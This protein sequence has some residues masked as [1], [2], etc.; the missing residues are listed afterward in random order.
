MC[1][2]PAALLAMSSGKKDA[3]EC[4]DG[5]LKEYILDNINDQ[6]GNKKENRLK[7]DH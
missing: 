5:K 4:R 7:N 2:W 1:R 6:R 3:G